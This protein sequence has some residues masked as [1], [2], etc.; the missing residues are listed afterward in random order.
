MTPPKLTDEEMRRVVD[1][2]YA[3]G[4][5]D[6][7][8][9]RSRIEYRAIES[10]VNAKWGAMLKQEPKCVAIIDVYDHDWHMSYLSLPVGRH[11]LYDQHFTY[12]A[13]QPAQQEPTNKESLTVDHTEL[14]R[15]ALEVMQGINHF[16]RSWACVEIIAQIKEALHEQS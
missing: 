10:A 7:E 3:Y 12:A 2:L 13:P 8:F 9:N 5:G 1:R 11:K 4:I 16:N 6:E 14:L 15:Q